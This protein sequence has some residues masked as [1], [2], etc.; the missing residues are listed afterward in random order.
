MP[1]SKKPLNKSYELEYKGEYVKAAEAI[2]KVYNE[3]SYEINLRAG[4][5]HYR[6]G[7]Y[8]ESQNYYQKAIA[9]KPYS[10]EAKFGYVYPAAALS[11]MD[12]VVAQYNKIL[13]INPQNTRANYF[14]GLIYYNKKDFQSAYKYF[15][16]VVNLY[17]FGYDAL[18]MYAWTNYQLGKTREAK[19]LFN[20]VPLLSPNDMS[21][22]EGLSLIK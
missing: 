12:Q 19:V 5:V 20:K 21:A 7:L 18:L 16:K 15:E 10:I 2:K 4:W 22:T 3:K 14:M 9:L 8:T 17:P 13:E 1:H 6:A 11:N